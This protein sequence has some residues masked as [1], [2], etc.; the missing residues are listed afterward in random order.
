MLYAHP[1]DVSSRLAD[2]QSTFLADA[3]AAAD[4]MIADSS[5]APVR[6]RFYCGITDVR[7]QN[8]SSVY[9]SADPINK[10]MSDLSSLGYAS[11]SKKYVVWWDGLPHD[12]AC[13]EGTFSDDNS[14]GQSN[15]NNAGPDY[16]I[17][18][19]PSGSSTFCGWTTVLHEIGHTLGAVMRGAPHQTAN[20]HC[21]DGSDIMC[22]VDGPG[23]VMTSSCPGAYK[24]FDCNQD[25]YFNPSP[26]RGSYLDT[27]WNTYRS[28]WLEPAFAAAQ[29]SPSP[30][31]PPP[32]P[33]SNPPA[34]QPT[35]T[36]SPSS[37]PPSSTTPPQAWM[38]MPSASIQRGN[39]IGVAWEGSDNSGSI[40]SYTARYRSASTQSGFGGYTTW[41]SGKSTSA[42]FTGT[43]GSTYCF[44]IKA[45]N[46][47][48]NES[49]WSPE[50]CSA[51]PLDD[52]SA[53]V[54]R[55]TR[56]SGAS[57]Y[58][59]T[60]TVGRRSGGSMMWN[61]LRAKSINVVVQMC[62]ACRY[63]DF[64]WNG[65]TIKRMSLYA[66]IAQMRTIPVA[67]FAAVQSGSLKIIVRSAVVV[68][69]SLGVSQA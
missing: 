54:S 42:E 57:F 29:P 52:R 8:P 26:A 48:G 19:K 53:S 2:M 47:S 40:A 5:S 59:G 50:R 35:P 49:A 16:A 33:P 10:I 9:G 63:A 34:P 1:S 32:P 46:A 51:V 28:S 23:V 68:V 39:T 17:Q 66:K 24:Y 21:T 27:H 11:V 65:R 64:L 69:D 15:H 12:S 7:M 31:P 18:Y 14:P 13:G 58:Q 3:A 62:R 56:S 41:V 45:V 6:P 4:R 37:Q 55:M 61:G 30:S 36:P 20:W 25:D 38:T 60:V 67:D 22:Y 43:P 44:S